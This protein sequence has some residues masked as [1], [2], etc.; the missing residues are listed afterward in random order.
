[1]SKKSVSPVSAPAISFD[2]TTVEAG[3]RPA[4]N[5]SKDA[6]N[7]YYR[8]RAG[9][10]LDALLDAIDAHPEAAK[11]AVVTWIGEVVGNRSDFNLRDVAKSHALYRPHVSP[12]REAK[13]VDNAINAVKS[14][15]PAQLAELLAALSK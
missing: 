15:S 3:S 6:Q 13:R 8:T 9:M 11:V 14:L 10:Q 2:F 1:M 4:S 12:E 5:A 7:A